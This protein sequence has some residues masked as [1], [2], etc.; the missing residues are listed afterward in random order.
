[1]NLLYSFCLFHFI[2]FYFFFLLADLKWA[3]QVEEEE[4][5]EGGSGGGGSG[6]WRRG[7]SSV[8]GSYGCCRVEDWQLTKEE[9]RRMKEENE[10]TIRVY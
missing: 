5:E 1:M 9:R 10:R 2:S 4:T 6:G 7:S 8:F 3:A